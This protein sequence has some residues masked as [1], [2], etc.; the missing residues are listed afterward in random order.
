[1]VGENLTTRQLCL[2]VWDAKTHF[3]FQKCPS[4]WGYLMGVEEEMPR[5][6]LVGLAVKDT[7]F[8]ARVVIGSNPIRGTNVKKPGTYRWPL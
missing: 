3:H 2:S 7:A 6:C 1:M 5:A 8:S 4:I